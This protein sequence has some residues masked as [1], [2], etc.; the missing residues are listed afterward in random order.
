MNIAK[1]VSWIRGDYI[2]AI[3]VLKRADFEKQAKKLLINI[4]HISFDDFYAV[5]SLIDSDYWED[6]EIEGRFYPL[7]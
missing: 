7:F 1:E 6:E 2:P 4:P 3:R 5:I